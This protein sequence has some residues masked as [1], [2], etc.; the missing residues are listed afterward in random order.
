MREE[1]RTAFAMKA[2]T[3]AD[4]FELSVGAKGFTGGS[5][6]TPIRYRVELSAPDG[7]STAG[8]KQ[9]LQHIKLVPAAGGPAIVIGNANQAAGV[10]ELRCYLYVAMQH[11]K[12][13]KGEPLGFQAA[14][15]DELL[16]KIE[17]FLTTQG[18]KVALAEEPALGE[19]GKAAGAMPWILLLVGVVALLVGLAALFTFM[20]H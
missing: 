9:A 1:T 19:A 20:R 17:S 12:R 10:A 13:W 6:E 4:H 15:Y 16:S 2:A 3:L 7:P 18:L 11:E 14:P 8:G 5:A